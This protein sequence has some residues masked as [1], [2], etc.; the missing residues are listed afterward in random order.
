MTTTTENWPIAVLTSRQ[1]RRFWTKVTRLLGQL[2]FA[3]EL[4][5][6]Y[7]C[8]IDEATPAA[9]RAT[10]VAALIYFILPADAVPDILTGLGFVDDASVLA[11]AVGAV[12]HHLRSHHFQAADETLDR[13]TKD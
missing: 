13:L 8:A 12:R 4:F 7:F 6:A 11:A 1:R 5:A 9:V 10:L 3:R 2:P